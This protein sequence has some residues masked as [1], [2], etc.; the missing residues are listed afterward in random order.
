MWR[1]LDGNHQFFCMPL[2]GEDSFF[3]LAFPLCGQQSPPL[4][5]LLVIHFPQPFLRW[6]NLMA[7]EMIQVFLYNHKGLSLETQLYIESQV[8]L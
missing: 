8:W 1:I 7:G 5:S 6:S 3:P 4:V 2:I